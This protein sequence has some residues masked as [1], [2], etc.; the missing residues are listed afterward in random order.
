MTHADRPTAA[1]RSRGKLSTTL[2]LTA[3]FLV[4]EVVG[5]VWTG[6]LGL[7]AAAGHMLADV[8]GLALALFAI[9]IGGRPPTPAKTYGYYRVEILAAFV[10]A[11][12]LL[13]V[14]GAVLVEAYQRL[15]TPPDVLG[16]PMLV[17][18]LVGLAANLGCAW[19]LRELHEVLHAR[20]GIDHT[21][22][23]LE[24]EP[25]AVLRIQGPTAV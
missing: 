14:A 23:Q 4:V 10:N 15:R 24:T 11:L 19:L 18:A 1:A 9:W 5:A 17:I 8:G 3:A 2:G 7:L 16:G 20:F 25:P 21:T 12:V 6:S 22:I 13:A